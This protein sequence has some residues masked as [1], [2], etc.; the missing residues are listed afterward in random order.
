MEEGAR[1]EGLIADVEPGVLITG[2]RGFYAYRLWEAAVATGA[3]LLWRM[4]DGHHLPVVRPLKDGS[5]ES[6][7]LDPK[8]RRRRA[9]QRYRGS[10]QI[11]EPSGILVRVVEYEV[12][13]V[14]AKA[15][16]SA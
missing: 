5:Y 15:R 11:E 6:F 1:A 16:F 7:L 13:P 10:M 9:N 2:D 12:T 8:V 4:P 3:D 14:R